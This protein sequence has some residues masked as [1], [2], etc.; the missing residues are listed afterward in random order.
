MR[1]W[2]G[3]G[4][5]VD[6][7]VRNEVYFTSKREGAWCRWSKEELK[8]GWRGE[9]ELRSVDERADGTRLKVRQ[10]SYAD[11]KPV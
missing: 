6:L 9:V 5:L 11:E 4:L 7:E 8:A 2:C 10:S 1:R 3:E